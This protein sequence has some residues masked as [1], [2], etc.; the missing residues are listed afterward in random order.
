M[1]EFADFDNKNCQVCL[2]GSFYDEKHDKYINAD[3]D[4]L[5]NRCSIQRDIMMRMISETPIN[6]RTVMI[7][8]NWT[9]HRARCPFLKLRKRSIGL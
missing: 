7:C 9:L 6:Y 2:K 8:E 5:P 4:N 3:D 1:S